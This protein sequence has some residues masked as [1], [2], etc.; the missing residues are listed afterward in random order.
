MEKGLLAALIA[1]ALLAVLPFAS[2][3]LETPFLELAISL[4][5][6]GNTVIVIDEEERL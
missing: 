6:S 5:K 3:K 1:L 4:A 2:A